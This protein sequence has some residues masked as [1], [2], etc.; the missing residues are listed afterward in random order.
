M[1]CKNTVNFK[2]IIQLVGVSVLSFVVQVLIIAGVF[3]SALKAADS[4]LAHVSS[5]TL[6]GMTVGI[7]VVIVVA[8]NG[9]VIRK[10]RSQTRADSEHPKAFLRAWWSGVVG[11][12]LCV[13]ALAIHIELSKGSRSGGVDASIKQTLSIA[14]TQGE[15]FY[16]A[17]DYS[18]EGVCESERLVVLIKNIE[19]YG[20][21]VSCFAHDERWAIESTL[22]DQGQ[23][24]CFDSS[25]GDVSYFETSSIDP[26]DTACGPEKFSARGN[27]TRVL[28]N[29]AEIEAFREVTG[30]EKIKIL[31]Q[32]GKAVAKM[33]GQGDIPLEIVTVTYSTSTDSYDYGSIGLTMYRGEVE[34]NSEGIE[35]VFFQPGGRIFV[36]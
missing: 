23:F 16:N 27:R 2:L 1:H 24:A 11:T 26:D 4:L 8:L 10:I 15:L 20:G 3:F 5:L 19:E 31:R 18:Y 35:T 21:V 14:R 9:V 17:S 33:K 29:V 32:V 34:L 36:K 28:F 25:S 12:F 13:S 22:I 30:E 7:Y 6:V